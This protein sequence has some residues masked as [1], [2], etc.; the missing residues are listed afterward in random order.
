M[1]K[2]N[3]MIDNSEALQTVLHQNDCHFWNI[4]QILHK[5]HN[6]EILSQNVQNMKLNAYME[7]VG[8]RLNKMHRVNAE[9]ASKKTNL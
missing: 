4:I 6:F 9:F 1:A 3:G 8:K 2:C 5:I 7:S